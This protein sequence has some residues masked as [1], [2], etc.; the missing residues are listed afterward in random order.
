[1]RWDSLFNDLEAQFSAER[2]LEKETEITERARVE[3]AGIELLDRLRAVGAGRVKVVLSGGSALL[4]SI[5]HLGNEWFVL[6]EG[7]RQ[8]LVP[9]PSVLTYQGVG[10]LA[11]KAAPR[12]VKP[13]GFAAALRA[14]SRDRA[15]VVV[16]VGAWGQQNL[17]TR[18]VID[19]VG[20]DH[21]DLAVVQE[22]EV[23]RVGNVVGVV[24][25]PFG[26]LVAVSSASAPEF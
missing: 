22:G 20:R 19:R 9:F 15:T 5:S 16:H 3:L 6:D 13:L 25:I 11:M 10:R 1:M 8:W 24:T 23:R 12:L 4:G 7:V 14:L 2:S 21:F 26:A 18:G 17:E